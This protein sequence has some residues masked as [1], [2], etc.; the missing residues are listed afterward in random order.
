MGVV[1]KEIRDASENMMTIFAA[2]EEM[3][4]SMEEISS[5]ADQVRSNAQAIAKLTTNLKKQVTQFSV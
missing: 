1:E 3:T 5:N 4:A 2:V